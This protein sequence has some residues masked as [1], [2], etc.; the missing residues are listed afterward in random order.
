M[1]VPRKT[2]SIAGG[3]GCF[4]ADRCV[5]QMDTQV[6]FPGPHGVGQVERRQEGEEVSMM[7]NL[8][9]INSNRAA[10]VGADNCPRVSVG[11][12]LEWWVG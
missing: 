11:G 7:G 9:T 12:Q 10:D 1:L 8:G 6:V 5:S 4:S 3:G 2:K